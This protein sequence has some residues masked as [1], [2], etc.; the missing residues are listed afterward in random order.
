MPTELSGMPLR[1]SDLSYSMWNSNSYN[2]QEGASPDS[3][4][5]SL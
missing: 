3:S 1:P 5:N 2:P 4:A